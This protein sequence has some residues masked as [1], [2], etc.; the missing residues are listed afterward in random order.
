MIVS[1]MAGESS[2]IT[3]GPVVIDTD[4]FFDYYKSSLQKIDYKEP[5]LYKIVDNF[6][7]DTSKAITK[8]E[9]LPI[10]EAVSQYKDITTILDL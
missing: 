2:I 8:I 1:T 4:Y 3:F 6:I 10:D 5:K 9:E 7:N